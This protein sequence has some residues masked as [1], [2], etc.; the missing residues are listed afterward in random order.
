M[1]K[2]IKKKK[3]LFRMF[4]DWFFDHKDSRKTARETDTLSLAIIYNMAYKFI[5]A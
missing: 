1:V 4:Q 5:E 3:D 2:F